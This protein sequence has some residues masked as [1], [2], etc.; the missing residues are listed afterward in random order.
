MKHNIFIK[1][2]YVI[3]KSRW[4][5]TLFKGEFISL[6]SFE[7]LNNTK[8][9]CK[10][11]HTIIDVGANKGQFQKAAKYH[12][13][14]VEIHSFEP[15]PELYE[16]LLKTTKKTVKNYNLALGNEIGQLT[17]N[18]NKYNHSSSFYEISEHNKNFPSSE[19]TKINVNIERLDNLSS[20]F[21]FEGVTLLKLDV[22]G[23]EL[24]VLKGGVNTIKQHINYI[25]VEI[26]FVKLYEN[27]PSFT[28]LNTYLNELGF[29]LKT[30]LDFNLGRDK[31][32][33]EADFLYEKSIIA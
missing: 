17:F 3:L 23:F 12:F 14:D 32:Y 26:N 20:K 6:A 5:N 15:I 25:I 13:P 22:Q 24:E 9:Q 29:E 1:R 8:K 30:M 19:T 4:I 28:K 2:V 10:E 18:K 16:K 21:N 7:I 27:Q 11:L 33:I 31:S